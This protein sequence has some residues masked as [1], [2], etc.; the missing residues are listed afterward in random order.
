[1]RVGTIGSPAW[2]TAI[3]TQIAKNPVNPN[4]QPLI[5]RPL[6]RFEDCVNIS[7]SDEAKAM[8]AAANPMK[9]KGD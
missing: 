9:P 2:V 8:Y 6:P 4:I 5:N 3:Y 7:I 1:M